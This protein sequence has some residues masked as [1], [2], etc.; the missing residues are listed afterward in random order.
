MIFYFFWLEIKNTLAAYLIYQW[1]RSPAT[2]QAVQN[3]FTFYDKRQ[4][5]AWI[6][7]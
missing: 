2:L 5:F 7:A 6:K 1:N 4:G 3:Y